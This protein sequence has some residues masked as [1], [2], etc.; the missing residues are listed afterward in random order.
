MWKLLPIIMHILVACDNSA[1]EE[2]HLEEFF[3]W[4]S[5]PTT[6]HLKMDI[7][8]WLITAKT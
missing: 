3:I 4:L 6:D 2:L 7:I 8:A 1:E 5:V